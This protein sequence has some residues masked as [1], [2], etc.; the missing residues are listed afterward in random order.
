MPQTISLTQTAAPLALMPVWRA[1]PL[2]LTGTVATPVLTTWRAQLWRRP[3]DVRDGDIEPLATV[4]GAVAAG[5]LNIA[6]TAQQMDVELGAG[7]G[8]YDDL[9][10]TIGGVDAD[11]EPHVVRA[12]WVRVQEGGFAADEYPATVTAFTVEN[13]IITIGYGGTT[14]QLQGVEVPIPD[15]AGEG[16]IVVINDILYF[17]PVGGT[18]AWAVQASPQ[19]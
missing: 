5:V 8:M 10:L 17:T 2:A 6:F 18:T 3:Q 9:W 16:S 13:D 14:Y 11:S 19:A 4:Y 1:T 12:D 7:N 15:G